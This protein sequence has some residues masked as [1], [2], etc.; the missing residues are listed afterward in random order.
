MTGGLPI[1]LNLASPSQLLRPVGSAAGTPKKLVE[2]DSAHPLLGAHTLHIDWSTQRSQQTRRPKMATAGC[3]APLTEGHGALLPPEGVAP[4]TLI[5]GTHPSVE[6]LKWAE[7]YGA[8][9]ANLQTFDT[10]AARKC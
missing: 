7:Y 9:R 3:A 4:H 5:L 1:S 2:L 6:S 10:Q 8:P